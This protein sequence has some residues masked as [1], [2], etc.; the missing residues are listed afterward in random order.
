MKLKIA[1][2]LMAFWLASAPFVNGSGEGWVVRFCKKNTEAPT[3]KLRIG[4]PGDKESQV[5]WTTWTSNMDPVVAVPEK[6][7]D[8][9]AI[10]VGAESDPAKKTVQF[11][12][13][14]NGK[15]TKKKV[16]SGLGEDE[17]QQSDSADCECE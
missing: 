4:V 17:S 9:K 3:V 16:F 12:F 8:I 2:S 15:T 13:Q 7:K 5:Y 14:Y 6:F 11:C 1:V 10:W